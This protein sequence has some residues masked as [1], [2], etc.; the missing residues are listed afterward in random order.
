M[1]SSDVVI[2]EVVFNCAGDETNVVCY[3]D[4]LGDVDWSVEHKCFG[5]E[6]AWVEGAKV[7]DLV[8]AAG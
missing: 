5:E 7:E 3:F 1:S 8:D 6:L 2:V 4:R